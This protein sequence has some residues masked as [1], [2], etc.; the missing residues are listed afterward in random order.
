MCFF[1]VRSFSCHRISADALAK[2]PSL[3][4]SHQLNSFILSRCSTC[5]SNRR[6]FHYSYLLSTVD[7]FLARS[8]ALCTFVRKNDV[9]FKPFKFPFGITARER[10]RTKCGKRFV[11]WIAHTTTLGKC[12]TAKC[13]P[14]V[15]SCCLRCTHS[16]IRLSCFPKCG[17]Q[18][19][20]T[21]SLKT[22]NFRDYLTKKKK[23]N[24]KT[25]TVYLI[26]MR[27]KCRVKIHKQIEQCI[28]WKWHQHYV[29]YTGHCLLCFKHIFCIYD[30]CKVPRSWT[31]DDWAK[32]EKH[33]NLD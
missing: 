18:R 19:S 32:K 9:D 28:L 17:I 2:K 25:K 27:W 10:E 5:D 11:F 26:E 31:V 23:R 3:L 1:S 16:G 13:A 14:F 21:F 15:W 30:A 33:K 6:I 4:F 12:S 7:T 20:I 8:I 24:E 22:F 29:H